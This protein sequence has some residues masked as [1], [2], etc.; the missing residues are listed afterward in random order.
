ML[1]GLLEKVRSV[2]EDVAG[3]LRLPLEILLDEGLVLF[4]RRAVATRAALGGI[5][6]TLKPPGPLRRVVEAR[7]RTTLEPLRLGFG[8]PL[9]LLCV[10]E[11]IGRLGRVRDNGCRLL[12]EGLGFGLARRRLCLACKGASASKGASSVSPAGSAVSSPA[13]SGISS[14][15][16]PLPE[17]APSSDG[18]TSR[19][20]G[21]SASSSWRRSSSSGTPCLRLSSRCSL[22]ASSSTP[23]ARNLIEADRMGRHGIACGRAATRRA[24]SAPLP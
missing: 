21:P 20:T 5:G 12:R 9:G 19:R 16:S 22:M 24:S 8:G 11:R 17:T 15:A 23:I 4:R 14:G 6:L 13:A 10:R 3:L 7:L 1:G 18:A 2:L